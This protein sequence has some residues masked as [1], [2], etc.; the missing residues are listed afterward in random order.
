MEPG[1]YSTG[2]NQVM[3]DNVERYQI[4]RSKFLSIHN[5]QRKLFSLLESKN[6]RG[7]SNKIVS[8]MEKENP[9]KILR[10]PWIQGILLKLYFLLFG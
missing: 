9:K 6:I 3:I 8:E 2:F 10:I 7:L 1:A 4:L 5:Y